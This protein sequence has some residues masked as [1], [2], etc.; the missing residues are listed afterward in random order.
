MNQFE[1]R[2]Y[3]SEDLD[4]L[5]HICL[6]TGLAG[7]DAT[8]TVHER[9]LG[10][11]YAAPYALFEPELCFVLTL[12]GTAVGY[13]LGTRDS[14]E[15]ARRCEQ[16]WWPALRKHYPLPDRDDRSRTAEVSRT[17]HRGY[18]P[19]PVS[20]QYPAHL[21]IDILP[22]G[23]GQGFGRQ[24]IELFISQLR[25]LEV[26]ALHFGVSGANRKAMGF[27]RHLGFKVIEEDERHILCGCHL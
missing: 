16:E 26:P 19:P 23:Q 13:I 17:I 14:V 20:K 25:A 22:E 12:A 15:F 2:P 4:R 3:R 9:I 11:V 1:I 5:Y 21:H 27:Y 10:D 8:G 18:Q 6:R 7:K 24:L